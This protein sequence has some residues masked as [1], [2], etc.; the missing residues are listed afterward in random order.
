MAREQQDPGTMIWAAAEISKMLGFYKQPVDRE[1]EPDVAT[2]TEIE[3][4]S[5]AELLGLLGEQR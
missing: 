1:P 3:A 2:V 4:M 5:D